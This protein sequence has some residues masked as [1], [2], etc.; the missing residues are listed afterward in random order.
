[1]PIVN[2]TLAMKYMHINSQYV[3]SQHDRNVYVVG[4]LQFGHHEVVQLL[5][6]QLNHMG[7]ILANYRG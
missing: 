5:R 4:H 6:I 3:N 1:M 7:G 2:P